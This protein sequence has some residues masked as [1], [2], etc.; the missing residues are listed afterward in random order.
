MAVFD[1]YILHIWGQKL[2]PATYYN[3]TNRIVYLQG[4]SGLRS[5]VAESIRSSSAD[6]D[7]TGYISARS[8]KPHM[9][10]AQ[11][12]TDLK[13]MQNTNYKVR[14]THMGKTRPLRSSLRAASTM[15][16]SRAYDHSGPE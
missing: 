16:C 4:M 12:P 7:T 8:D 3:T 15:C 14:S 6:G 10:E 11:A 2:G 1:V 13:I 5:A 9:V